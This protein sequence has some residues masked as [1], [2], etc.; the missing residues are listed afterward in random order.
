MREYER[1]NTTCANAY[2]KPMMES[3]LGR[4]AAR[5][6]DQGAVCPIFLIHSGGGIISI[7]AAAA[8]PVRLVESGPAGRRDLCRRHRQAAWAGQGALLRHGRH[9]GQDL[10]YPRRRAENRPRVRSSPLLPFK[11]GSGMP[12]SI[13][14]IDMVEIGAG[15]GSIAHLDSMR[16]IRVGPESAA[17]RTRPGLLSAGR[18][19]PC[20]DRRRPCPWPSRSRG[21]CGRRDPARPRVV[22]R[23]IDTSCRR[24]ARPR[25]AHLPPMAWPRWWTRTWPTPP[26]SMPSRTARIWRPTR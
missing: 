9:D 13:P 26:A 23:G 7:D 5:L 21:L 4:L 2:V 11:K 24:P 22:C 17:S 20:R 1:F 16:Q 18:H 8:F 12:I 25:P 6:A 19:A 3:Y 10:P 15:G 14:V